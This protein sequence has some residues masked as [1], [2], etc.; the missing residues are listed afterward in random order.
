M[1]SED[2]T[3]DTLLHLVQHVQE[4]RGSTWPEFLAFVQSMIHQQRIDRTRH[5]NRQKRIPDPM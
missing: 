5:Q 1:D 3:Q 4:F 2:L